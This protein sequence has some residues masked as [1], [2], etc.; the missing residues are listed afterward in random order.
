MSRSSLARN[1]SSLTNL[2]DKIIAPLLLIECL[3]SR[4]P[5]ARLHFLDV[6]LHVESFYFVTTT[7]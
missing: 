7:H 1:L 5:V 4:E 2:N 6:A 3:E